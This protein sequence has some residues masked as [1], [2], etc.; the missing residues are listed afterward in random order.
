MR[1][2]RNYDNTKLDTDLQS[3]LWRNNTEKSITDFVH[4]LGY[5]QDDTGKIWD[6]FST[7]VQF[8]DIAG[9]A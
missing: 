5:T 3:V 8:G 2:F 9:P 7:Y 6:I 1:E 4:Q